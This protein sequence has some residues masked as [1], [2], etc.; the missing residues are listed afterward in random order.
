MGAFELPRPWLEVFKFSRGQVLTIATMKLCYLVIFIATFFLPIQECKSGPPREPVESEEQEHPLVKILRKR[1]EPEGDKDFNKD[2]KFFKDGEGTLPGDDVPTVLATLISTKE[3]VGKS[4][5]KYLKDVPDNLAAVVGEITVSGKGTIKSGVTAIQKNVDKIKEQL[6]GNGNGEAKEGSIL[7]KIRDIERNL[8]TKDKSIGFMVENLFHR[9]DS[10]SSS[11][12]D[13]VVSMLTSL[14]MVSTTVTTISQ[15]LSSNNGN[16]GTLQNNVDILLRDV[17]KVDAKV[18]ANSGKLEMLH[19]SVGTLT[20]DVDTINT[21]VN[22][23]GVKI[24]DLEGKLTGS[25]EKLHKLVMS[26]GAVDD[27]VD[28]NGSKLDTLKDNVDDLKLDVGTLSTNVNSNVDKISDLDVKVTGSR[29]Q[30]NELDNDLEALDEKVV[31]NGGKLDTLQNNVD[32]LKLDVGTLGTNVINNGGKID[33]LDVK[34]TASGEQLI[35]LVNDLEILDDK[36]DT[37][38]RNLDLLLNNVG[39]VG[40]DVIAL[41][42]KLSITKTDIE[43][44]IDENAEKIHRLEQ[45]LA[46]NTQLQ[47]ENSRLLRKLFK[48]VGR[49]PPA[50]FLHGRHGKKRFHW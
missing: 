46:E 18:V 21:N 23:N 43:A 10:D 7:K 20:T 1:L 22:S 15:S 31:I 30:L 49:A 44:K 4:L 41:D 27:K 26:V 25:G 48:V 14:N 29:N 19:K 6:L 12:S 8:E 16:L 9:S 13:K 35:E 36:V 17:P 34:V 45:I 24:S 38:K 2:S 28:S 32:D 37:N 50:K 11:I 5:R 3:V 39:I 42:G 47:K 40:A 33:S